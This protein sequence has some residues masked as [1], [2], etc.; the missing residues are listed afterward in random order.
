MI[1]RTMALS[2]IRLIRA[3]EGTAERTIESERRMKVT[4][5]V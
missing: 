1:V 4:G 3:D 2:Q 5:C